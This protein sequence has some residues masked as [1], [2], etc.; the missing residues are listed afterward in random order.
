MATTSPFRLL[1]TSVVAALSL[2]VS[3]AGAQAPAATP[4]PAL[5]NPASTNCIAKGGQLVIETNGA[6]GQFGVCLFPDNLQCEEWAMLRGQCRTGGIKVTGFVTPA[7]R[8]CAITG[9]SY[10]V[11]SGSN[12]PAER[13]TCT[14]P[15][16]KS[17]D[18]G[19][20]FDGTCAR[21]GP[22]ATAAPSP[23]A[24]IR[25]MFACSEGKSIDATFHNG[26]QSSVDLVLSGGRTLT[27]PQARSGSGARYANRDESIV[28]WNKGDTAFLEEK[29][30]T[31]YAD[32]ATRK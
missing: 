14:F 24:T 6:G 1:L 15:N 17:C 9:G 18:A 20:Y 16:R 29:G 12:T 25:A 28:F 2:A 32:C 3:A 27:L 19:A 23:P 10:K 7:A 26:K 4:Q 11:T 8:Y 5:A 31:T 21:T 13:G 30:K 22:P